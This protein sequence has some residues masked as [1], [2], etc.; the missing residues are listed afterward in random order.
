MKGR[1]QEWLYLLDKHLEEWLL[2][3]LIPAF[4]M[5]IIADVFLRYLFDYSTDW[6]GEMSRY[7]LVFTSYIGASL[8]IRTQRHVRVDIIFRLVGPS[9]QRVLD[10]F[11]DVCFAILCGYVVVFSLKVIQLHVKYGTPSASLTLQNLGVTLAIAYTA[12]PFGW[13]LMGFRLIQ[14]MVRNLVKRRR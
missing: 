13:G 14:R 9:T 3:A 10:F 12:L 6:G 7:L 5:I 8:C 2:I 11:A 1:A 4:S